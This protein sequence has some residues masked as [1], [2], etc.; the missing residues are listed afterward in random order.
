MRPYDILILHVHRDTFAAFQEDIS[1]GTNLLTTVLRKEGFQVL[2][3]RGFAAEAGEWIRS[4]LQNP[5]ARAVGFY[6]DF[7]N[8]SLVEEMCRRI[9]AAWN[10]PVIVG[11]PQAFS[12]K[13]DFF[14]SSGCCAVVRGEAEETLPELLSALMTGKNDLSGIAGINFYGPDGSWI[15][16]ADR[17]PTRELDSLPWPDFTME[18]RHRYWTS[19]PVMS[20]RGC[21]FRCGFCFEGSV[22][23]KVRLRGVADVMQEI[24]YN[25]A[26]HPH[27]KSVFF[28]DDTFTLQPQRMEDFCRELSLLRKERDFVWFC[29]GHVQTLW[30]R[31]EL[32][33]QMAQA[34]L[35]KIFIGVESGS[36]LVLRLYRKQTTAAMIEETVGLL[37]RAGVPQIVGNI[38][39]G[40]PRESDQTVRESQD[41]VFRLLEAHP[42]KFDCLGFFLVPFPGTTVQ[43]DPRRL[44]LRILDNRYQAVMDDIPYT[45]TDAYSFSDLFQ[46]RREFHR[47]TLEK[48][49]DLFLS[50]KIPRE[51]MTTVY[52]LHRRYGID[53]RWIQNIF[54]LEPHTHHYYSM[55]ADRSI[56]SSDGLT[57]RELSRRRPY[58]L[59]NMWSGVRRD[60]GYPEIAGIPLSPLE[61]E[62]LQQCSG[63]LTLQE[64][65]DKTFPRFAPRFT[66]KAVY[67]RLVRKVVKGFEDRCWL[68]FSYY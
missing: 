20:G 37:A 11:G 9:R 38:I 57:A 13:E 2:Y 31:P 27:L 6:C 43:T 45:E 59:M 53:S 39:L 63:K 55:L 21:P 62:I 58:R 18:P 54:R 25:F 68:G 7:E 24:R 46:V 1:I 5:G 19:L 52:D 12:L 3:F 66:S 42:G 22:S 33:E 44:G 56:H 61:Y 17:K 36:D 16:T 29:E 4:R 10:I 34:G 35:A 47:R 41:L 28:V 30:R 23:K 50:G 40:G 65:T 8:E 67:G 60:N 26:R 49:R 32:A 64:V 15:Q 14:R 51:T 48:M